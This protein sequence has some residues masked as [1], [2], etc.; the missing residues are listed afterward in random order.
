M[1]PYITEYNQKFAVEPEAIGHAIVPLD[2]QDGP[3]TLLSVR[4][5]QTTDNCGC[6]SFQGFTFQNVTDKSIAKKKISFLLSKQI[7]FKAYNDRRYYPV[8]VQ[9]LSNNRKTTRLPD[10]TKLLLEAVPKL[11]F[12]EQFPWIYWKNRAGLL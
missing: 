7:G 12:L 6:F 11:Q 3:D 8:T 5:E 10:V 1:P 9:G 2:T 4:Y